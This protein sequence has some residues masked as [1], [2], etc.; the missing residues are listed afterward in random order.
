[1]TKMKK[2]RSCKIANDWNE[3]RNFPFNLKFSLFWNIIFL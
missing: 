2:M 3:L 1:M